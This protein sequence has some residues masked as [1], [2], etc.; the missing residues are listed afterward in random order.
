MSDVALVEAVRIGGVEERDTGVER[1][2]EDLD[3]AIVVS[4]GI[5]RQAHATD[6]DRA[7]VHVEGTCGVILVDGDQRKARLMKTPRPKLSREEREEL[8]TVLQ[9]RFEKNMNRHKGLSWAKVRARLEAHAEKLWSLNEMERTG[10]EPDVVGQDNKTGEYLF[11]DCS[12]EKSWWPE[13]C[14]LRPRSV[15]LEE[16]T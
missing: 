9:T 6:R 13:K 5:G 10:G 8:L 12:A 4:I 15:G 3:R 1:G 14:L 11:Y 7:S 16:G 2:M